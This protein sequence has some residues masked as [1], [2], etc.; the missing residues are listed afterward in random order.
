MDI[1]S[2]LCYESLAQGSKQKSFSSL[3]TLNICSLCE[4]FRCVFVSWILNFV[5]D[6]IPHCVDHGTAYGEIHGHQ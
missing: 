2:L 6:I 5:S 1:E 4:K 3:G